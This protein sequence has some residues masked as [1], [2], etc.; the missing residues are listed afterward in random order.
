MVVFAHLQWTM[1]MNG[2]S[3]PDRGREKKS[4]WKAK[5]SQ[6]RNTKIY[7]KEYMNIERALKKFPHTT[8]EA[9]LL[10]DARINII[11]RMMSDI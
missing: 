10:V 11:H 1:T 4:E 8:A 6:L 7:M 5:A 9:R 2:L 3:H